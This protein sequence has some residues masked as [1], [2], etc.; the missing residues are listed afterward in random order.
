MTRRGLILLLATTTAAG[1][2]AGAVITSKMNS[3][4]AQSKPGYGIAA[5]AGQRVGQDVDGPYDVDPN[6]PEPI[7]ALPGHEKWT[8]G[9]VESVF[10]E[11]PNRVFILERGEIPNLKRPDEVPYPSVGPSI[12]FPVAQVPWRNASVGPVTAAGNPVWSGKIGVDARWEHCIVVVDANGN[13]IEDWTK[14]DKMLR[15]PHYITINPYDPEKH[16]WVVDDQSHAVYEFTHDGKE[17]VKTL[18]T[19]YESGNDE[20]HFN[21]PTFINWLPDG[22]MFVTDGYGNTRV[23]KLDKD[24]NYLMT[25]GTPSMPPDDT[26]P[27]TFHDVHGVVFDLPRH[28]VLVTDRSDHRIE[29]FDENGKF[30]DQW[31]TGKPSTPQFLYKAA[32]GFLWIAD[33]TTAKIIKFDLYGHLLYEWGSGG[34]WPG[35]LWNVHGMSV[36]QE[37]N[38]YLAEVNNGRAEKFRPR[39]GANPDLLVGKPMYAAWK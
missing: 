24:G 39:A 17:L 23:V 28:R 27:G 13:L 38:L 11:S 25:W 18:G 19:P 31:T 29:I 26:R 1:I 3:V 20:K 33:G 14:W 37:G 6:W 12:S 4:Q 21:R 2:M 9:A 10:A 32:D 30:L 34:D 15:R 16:V 35:A 7:S 36:D 22:T 5:L 8:Y